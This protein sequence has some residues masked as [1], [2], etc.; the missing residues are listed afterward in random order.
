MSDGTVS[1]GGDAICDNT[2]MRPQDATQAAQSFC[3]NQSL[4]R[5]DQ[6]LISNDVKKNISVYSE[7]LITVRN[8]RS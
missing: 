2:R 3:N 1:A 4:C 7:S 6:T 5:Y 8:D